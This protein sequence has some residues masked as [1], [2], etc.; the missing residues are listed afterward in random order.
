MWEVEDRGNRGRAG[1]LPAAAATV[2]MFLADALGV[3]LG[4]GVDRG[5]RLRAHT[6]TTDSCPARLPSLTDL[7]WIPTGKTRSMADVGACN[8]CMHG[9]KV[10]KYIVLLATLPAL[11]ASTPFLLTFLII[12]IIVDHRDSGKDKVAKEPLEP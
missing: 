5:A 4:E 6:D 10:R 7:K 3:G 9:F 12:I 2:D 11:P 1:P 8:R